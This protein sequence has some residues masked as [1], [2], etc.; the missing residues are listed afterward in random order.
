MT[1]KE[2]IKMNADEDDFYWQN[3]ILT[4]KKLIAQGDGDAVYSSQYI[5]GACLWKLSSGKYV[6]MIPDSNYSLLLPTN[7][8]FDFI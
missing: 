6:T 2:T 1:A 7:I 3:K 8:N 5:S 4:A